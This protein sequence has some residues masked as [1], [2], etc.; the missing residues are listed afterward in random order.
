ML[1]S[2]PVDTSWPGERN[3]TAAKTVTSQAPT[4]WEGETCHTAHVGAV[5]D[6]PLVWTSFH[7]PDD[8]LGVQPA[9]GKLGRVYRRESVAEEACEGAAPGDQSKHVILAR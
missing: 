2:A 9:G 3:F 1:Q 5:K 6:R 7:A 4:G 8:D